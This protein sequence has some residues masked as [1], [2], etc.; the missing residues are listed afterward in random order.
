[1][2]SIHVKWDTGS[3]LAVDYGADKCQKI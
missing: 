3:R 2:G 1:M